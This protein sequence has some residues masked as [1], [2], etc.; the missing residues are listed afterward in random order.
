MWNN[1]SEKIR[2]RIKRRNWSQISEIFS[3][4]IMEEN[5][6]NLNKEMPIMAHNLR[7]HQI[8]RQ[9]RKFPGHIIF[10]TQKEKNKPCQSFNG[11]KKHIKADLLG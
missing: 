3:T 1:K 10:Q 7:E 4:N 5:I 2:Y 6:P 11:K 9:K 8:H